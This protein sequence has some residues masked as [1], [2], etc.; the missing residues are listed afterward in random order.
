MLTGSLSN[1]LIPLYELSESFPQSESEARMAYAQSCSIVTFMVKEYG[2]DSLK[3]CVRLIAE[4]RGIDEA[5]AGAT[6]IDSAWLDRK[7]RKSLKSRY[8]W[9]SFISSWVVLWGF[10]VFIALIAYVRRRVR[11]QRILREWEEEE[12]LWADFGDDE[13]SE[14]E[15]WTYRP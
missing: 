8:K 9:I 3:E 4:G 1:S 13:G 12:K 5:L 11:N 10:V 15:N 7:W 14:S 2:A 6:G